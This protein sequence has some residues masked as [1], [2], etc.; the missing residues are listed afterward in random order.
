MP[1]QNSLQLHTEQNDETLICIE[2]NFQ[3]NNTD[4]DEVDTTIQLILTDAEISLK[5]VV[6]PDT[7]ISL[8]KGY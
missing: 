4:S 3:L 2:F 7:E 6:K 8:K 1:W 5:K